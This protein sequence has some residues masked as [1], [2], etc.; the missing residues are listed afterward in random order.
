MFNIF[1]AHNLPVEIIEIIFNNLEPRDIKKGVLLIMTGGNS[2]SRK[3][4][5]A[6]PGS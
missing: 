2:F 4:I 6:G 5:G 1:P 3:D